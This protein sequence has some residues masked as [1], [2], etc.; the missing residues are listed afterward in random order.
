MIVEY[1]AT[2]GTVNIIECDSAHFTQ[3]LCL[4]IYKGGACVAFVTNG[5]YADVKING[6]DYVVNYNESKDA[7]IGNLQSALDDANSQIENLE[8]LINQRDKINELQAQKIRD[9]M[10]ELDNQN[11]ISSDM[12]KIKKVILEL[13]NKGYEIERLDI[14]A[15]PKNANS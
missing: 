7:V 12:G 3:N 13:Y 8:G 10:K 15:R 6:K 14:I 2:D 11:E 4:H 1:R 5:V 9:L